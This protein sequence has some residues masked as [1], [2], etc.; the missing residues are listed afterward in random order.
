MWGK[1]G[2]SSLPNGRF[3][4]YKWW[5]LTVWVFPKIGVPPNHPMILGFPLFSPSILGYQHFWKHPFANW[6]DPPGV[7]DVPGFLDPQGFPQFG[8]RQDWCGKISLAFVKL[9]ELDHI[10]KDWCEKS[11]M[12]S[13]KVYIGL[14][15]CPGFQSP[16]G[17]FCF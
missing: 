9:I 13:L 3:M 12:K 1:V 2:G 16:P 8:L 11:T 17:L 5:L 7:P 4:K 15:P 6:D 14:S 10:S